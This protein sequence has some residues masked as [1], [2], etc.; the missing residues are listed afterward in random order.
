LRLGAIHH[1]DEYGL[2][3]PSKEPELIQTI[4]AEEIAFVE[5]WLADW[6]PPAEKH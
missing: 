6:K 5:A 1:W 3:D 4:H 2:A